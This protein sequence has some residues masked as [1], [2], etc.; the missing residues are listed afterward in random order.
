MNFKDFLKTNEKK[1]VTE[2]VTNFI[3][4]A[5]VVSVLENMGIAFD[6]Q[7][8]DDGSYYYFINVQHSLRYNGDILTMYRNENIVHRENAR[9]YSEILDV[10]T[11]WS[12]SYE[13]D[14]V[15]DMDDENYEPTDDNGFDPE[16]ILADLEQQGSDDKSTDDETDDDDFDENQDDDD[17]SDDDD[18]QDK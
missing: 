11:K 6:R 13:F 2:D 1:F 15:S 12:D 7:I 5:D 14:L 16:K 4:D 18:E 8:N 10:I 3:D 9:N 17:D